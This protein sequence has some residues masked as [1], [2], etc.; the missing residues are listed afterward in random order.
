MEKKEL[1]VAEINELYNQA[2]KMIK[3]VAD[4]GDKASEPISEY[5][6]WYTKALAVIR[7]LMPDRLKEFT[8][9]YKLEKRKE[10]DFVTYTISD[11]LL[12]LRVT[13]GVYKEQVVNPQMAFISKY[14]Q[15]I[16]ILGSAKTRV[17]SILSDIHGVLKAE[18]YDDELES[19]MDLYKHG[20]LRAAGT[21]AGVVLEGHLGNTCMNHN[22]TLTKKNPTLADYNEALKNNE[23]L[24]VANWRWVQR[25][26]DIR[27][28][29]AHAKDREPT[30][31]EVL[32]LIN[33][34]G[35]AI[36]TIF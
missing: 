20:H 6:I 26:G 3:E 2:V 19:A 32:E 36:K 29:C 9:L 16:A 28:L 23:V 25:L 24:D 13:R 11:Y 5:Q 21:I 7:Q 12:G 15:Q 10:I 31:D 33:G 27:N 35:K 18:L 1:V 14:Q 4:K 22:I 17:E 8:E 30:N 34:V